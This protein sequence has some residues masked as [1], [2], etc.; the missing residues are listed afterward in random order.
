M[1]KT[2]KLFMSNTII[3]D[4]N[5]SDICDIKKLYLNSAEYY[6][7]NLLPLVDEITDDF[8]YSGLNSA[9]QTG[10]AIVM[11][12]ENK[13]I[14][15]IQGYPSKTLRESH[16]IKDT[17]VIIDSYY[18]SSGYAIKLMAAVQKKMLKM[19]YIKAL[20]FNV[21]GHNTASARGL[22]FFGCYEVLRTQD[23]LLTCNGTFMEDIIYRWDNPS[24]IEAD[25]LEYWKFKQKSNNYRVYV[26]LTKDNL[27]YLTNTSN[28]SR[29]VS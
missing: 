19:T 23:A 16:L 28:A 2:N 6:P 22:K 17:R 1:H 18:N 14:G 12:K 3:R 25:F 4:A 20:M 7:D 26:D 8:I 11:E 15:Y 21:R 13:I 27:M 24:F 9:I 29:Y 10:F 5:L